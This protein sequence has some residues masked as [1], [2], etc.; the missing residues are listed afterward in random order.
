[1]PGRG[2]SFNLPARRRAAVALAFVVT[3][4]VAVT[5]TITSA[6][7][8]T[9]LHLQ[10]AQGF[11]VKPGLE[12]AALGVLATD[13]VA[14]VVDLQAL[15]LPALAG[16]VLQHRFAWLPVPHGHIAVIAGQRRR[17]CC[18]QG[19]GEHAGKERFHGGVPLSRGSDRWE[20][21]PAPWRQRR[22]RV[23][24]TAP[25]VAFTYSF[26]R[27]SWALLALTS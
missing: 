3:V 10:H 25:V 24:S 21:V 23:L 19:Q 15:H 22:T 16:R 17:R 2:L 5:V 27:W 7:M 20:R 14:A 18:A 12:G 4:T 6:A 8:P 1:M 11:G 13:F 26:T 9:P